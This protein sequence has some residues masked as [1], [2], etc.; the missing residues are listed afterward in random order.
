[1]RR[2]AAS[3][4]SF[5]LAFFLGW[6]VNS[7]ARETGDVSDKDCPALK[8]SAFKSFDGYASDPSVA[9][10]QA[11]LRE[12]ETALRDAIGSGADVNQPHD[13]RDF[14]CRIAS[15]PV[16]AWRS[17]KWTY[18]IFQAA[19]EQLS[20]SITGELLRAGARRDAHPYDLDP[21]YADRR[22]FVVRM[23]WSFYGRTRGSSDG[24]P[25][26]DWSPV[27]AEFIKQG[28]DMSGESLARKPAGTDRDVA[29]RMLTPEERAHFDAAITARSNASK[30]AEDLEK[31][32]RQRADARVAEEVATINAEA[33][34]I[35]KAENE[36]LADAIGASVCKQGTLRA[37]VCLQGTPLCEKWSNDGILYG[38]VEGASPDR[39]RLQIRVGGTLL[40]P[41]V[42]S[43]APLYRGTTF[44]GLTAC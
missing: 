29:Y 15:K 9:L 12:D 18:P 7:N 41:G 23:P 19:Q 38:Y 36:T 35:A 39:R 20:P 5:L 28:F 25:D 8:S 14:E 40:P 13:M 1:M 10:M 26:R 4:A 2:T 22:E 17:P 11:V 3:R 30:H 42:Q 44:D 21:V 37:T 6:P 43:A 32:R 16:A 33:A 34:A 31:E 24:S 27:M